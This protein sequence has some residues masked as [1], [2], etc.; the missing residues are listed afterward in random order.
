VA[1]RTPHGELTRSSAYAFGRRL[2]EQRERQGVTLEAI[3]A[4]TKINT[5]L[6]TALER[7]DVSAWPGG[8]FRRAFVR[9]YATA[10]G[11][12]SEPIVAEFARVFPDHGTA[13][14]AVAAPEATSELRMTLALDRR[15]VATAALTRVT[16]AL[17]EVCLIVAVSLAT[18]AW[19]PG[20][21]PWRIC[22]AVALSYYALGKMFPAGSRVFA[23]IR[24]EFQ[25]LRKLP[26]PV[27][28][29]DVREPLHLVARPSLETPVE[30]S[31]DFASAASPLR[32]AS[33]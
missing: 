4:A 2:R 21:D 14:A 25:S 6:L 32:S 5:S 8:I 33:R 13:T 7:G 15:V 19:A 18:A 20:L 1:N 27:A 30:S 17:L 16:I 28:A 31:E 12:A 24:S 22:A 11:A 26:Q 29:T 3:A 10:I 9:A 23:N